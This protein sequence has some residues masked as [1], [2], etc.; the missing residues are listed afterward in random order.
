M[1]STTPDAR[2][3]VAEVDGV[4]RR[5]VSR[6]D[7]NSLAAVEHA[8]RNSLPRG[9]IPGIVG[10]QM[11]T[12]VVGRKQPGRVVGVAHGLVK[13]NNS[14]EFAAGA[15]PLLQ[16]RALRLNKLLHPL[17]ECLHRN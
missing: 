15:V 10:M 5:L 4:D 14:V 12:A 1:S 7:S 9:G 11:V 2:V 8:E 3:W 6:G 13:I 17:D 16:C